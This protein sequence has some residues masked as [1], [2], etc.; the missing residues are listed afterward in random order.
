MNA[1]NNELIDKVMLKI[2]TDPDAW[3][4]SD[5]ICSTTA[6]FAGHALIESGLYEMIMAKDGECA[7]G[8]TDCSCT[9][10]AFVVNKETR[11]PINIRSRAQEL[12]GFT[13]SEA[14]QV[15]LDTST[16]LGRMTDV[17]AGIRKQRG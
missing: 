7:Y 10:Q 9:T 14:R 4:Q 8:W 16:D 6:C 3:N 15:F 17:I 2:S 13:N 12:L 11:S 5:W 1:L